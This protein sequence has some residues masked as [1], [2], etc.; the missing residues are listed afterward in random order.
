MFLGYVSPDCGVPSAWSGA[1]AAVLRGH[2]AWW[3]AHQL[4]T[5]TDWGE[6]DLLMLDLPPGTGDVQLEV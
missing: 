5:G 1:G 6:I 3:V 2:M 4:L